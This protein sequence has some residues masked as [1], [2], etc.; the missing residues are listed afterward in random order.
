V[1][2]LALSC[3]MSLPGRMVKRGDSDMKASMPPPKDRRSTKSSMG[4]SRAAP[5]IREMPATVVA[6]AKANA[7]T[8]PALPRTEVQSDAAPKNR[9]SAATPTIREIPAV[10]GNALRNHATIPEI[11]RAKRGRRSSLPPAPDRPPTS[12]ARES[13]RPMEDAA[14]SVIPGRAKPALP[15]LSAYLKM[16][17]DGLASFAASEVKGRVVRGLVLDPV[18]PPPLGLGLPRE[19]EEI[20]RAPPSAV[21]WVPEVHV[22]ALQAGMYDV[23]FASGTKMEGFRRWAFDRSMQLLHAAEYKNLVALRKPELL[24]E[25]LHSR[26]ASFY[27]GS[28]LDLVTTKPK[29]T[30]LRVTHSCPWPEV[31]REAFGELFRASVVIAGAMSTEVDCEEVSP[32]VA[33]Y[34]IRFQ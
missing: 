27:R 1:K 33:R 3:N 21:S 2:H 23:I 7:P 8:Q 11:P 17:P 10:R 14:Y 18:H 32:T 22:S 9:A 34:T 13:R 16:L 29:H 26:W 25:M 5:T 15:S 6:E 28:Q 30:T 12:R 24:L 4:G 20:L 19:L 31:T